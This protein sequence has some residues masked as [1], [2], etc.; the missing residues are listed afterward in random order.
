M[1]ALADSAPQIVWFG[2]SSYLIGYNGYR[3]LVDP[4]LFGTSSPVSFI[5]KPF[6]VSAP[7]VPSDIPSVDLLVLTHDHY[8]HLDYV[9]LT[10]LRKQ[11]RRVV[12]PLGVGSHL[13]QW[14]FDAAIITELDWNEALAVNNE[15]V[16]TA[17]PARHF[18]GRVFARNKTLWNAYVLAWGPY[19]IFVGGDS[20]YDTQFKLTGD[21]HG[22]FDIAF[23][24]CGQYGVDW[25]YIH[26]FPEETAKA[27]QD[28]GARQL[29]PV[30]WAKFVL[31]SH[32]W[33]E[34]VE[35]LSVAAA[36]GGVELVTPLIGAATTLGIPTVANAWWRDI[37]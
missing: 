36:Q 32:S 19:K 30:H 11:F 18:S 14:G 37:A 28:L 2:H 12:C 17:V 15:I 25:P 33:K 9:T 4:V 20:G 5:G 27:A 24:E 13:A 21:N 35:R 26:L 29:F 7:F 22:P 34:P 3:V 10:Q 1:H 6:P 31:A 16:L 8:D 23:L